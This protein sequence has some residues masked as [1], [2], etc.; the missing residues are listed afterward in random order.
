MRG[1]SEVMQLKAQCLTNSS[2]L[3]ELLLQ[4]DFCL[5][6]SIGKAEE[7]GMLGEKQSRKKPGKNHCVL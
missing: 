2:C 3:Q 7:I 6:Q 1:P 4:S 5:Q